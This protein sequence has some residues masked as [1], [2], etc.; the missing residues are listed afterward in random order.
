MTSSE[1]RQ[2]LSSRLA[3]LLACLVSF[4]NVWRFPAL[5]H[6]TSG[7]L[8]ALL[9]MCFEVLCCLTFMISIE[10][11]GG[12]FFLPYVLGLVFVGIPLLVQ[13]IAMGQ[14]VRKSDVAISGHLSKH[15]RGAGLAG[16]FCGFF[17]VCYYIPLISWCLR[18]FFGTFLKGI[19]W[20]RISFMMEA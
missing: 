19:P 5:V 16:I 20:V 18:V 11:G 2:T 15:F 12:A 10:Y 17:V 8:G 3:F 14:H 6:G 13:E 1:E 9:V 4:G 7:S